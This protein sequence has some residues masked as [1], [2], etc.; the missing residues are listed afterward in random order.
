MHQGAPRNGP[1]A[2]R[3]GGRRASRPVGGSGVP[4]RGVHG[5]SIRGEQPRRRRGHRDGQGVEGPRG[6]GTARGLAIRDVGD[7]IIG[8]LRG[9]GA[10]RRRARSRHRGDGGTTSF[11]VFA[12]S[13]ATRTTRKSPGGGVSV[14]R[15]DL[16]V[17]V[18]VPEARR[19]PRG[20]AGRR[21]RGTPREGRQGRRRGSA[22]E[23][24]QQQD[25]EGQQ[26]QET[27][28]EEAGEDQGRRGRL[29]RGRG[30]GGA[31]RPAE[32][33]MRGGGRGLRNFPR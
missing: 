9:L 22:K 23:E 3:G 12:P 32:R 28:R 15:F 6:I 24:H 26:G 5:A 18:P 29:V 8:M 20:G 19:R 16:R 25:E 7:A 21:R 14:P 4:A 13:T 33:G 2:P 30:R 31:A 1:P 10:V 11:E 27:A 17:G